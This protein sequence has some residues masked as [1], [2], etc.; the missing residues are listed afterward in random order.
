MG[1]DVSSPVTSVVTKR[2]GTCRIHGGFAEMMGWRPTMEDAHVA[3]VQSDWA[4]L[5]IF[6]GH[7]GGECSTFVSQRL[8]EELKK[9]IPKDDVALS[10]LVM[11]VDAEFL[12]TGQSS[13]STGTF[14]I[15]EYPSEH[16]EKI[17]LRVGNVGDS[18]VLLGRRDGTMVEGCGTDGGL[19]VDHKPDQPLERERIER[20]GGFV[21]SCS[22]V[23]RVNGDLALSRAFGDA[24]FKGVKGLPPECQAVSALPDLATFECD[25]TNIL[26]LV[27]DGISEGNFPNRAAVA[28]AAKLLRSTCPADPANAA[29]AVCREALSNGSRDNLSCMVVVFGDNAVTGEEIRLIPGPLDNLL[30]SAF[31]TSYGDM[32]ARAGLSLAEAVCLRYDAIE[33]ELDA[34]E[35]ETDVD[36]TIKHER[37]LS[38]LNIEYAAFA[39][40][41]PLDFVRGSAERVGWFEAWLKRQSK[42]NSSLDTST[43]LLINAELDALCKVRVASLSDVRAAVD[44]HT[45]L[46]WDD[47]LEETCGREGFLISDDETDAPP[48]EALLG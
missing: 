11:S 37:S 32:A 40:G 19:T 36:D 5:G 20:A 3:Y 27:C 23:A 39:E 8:L 34:A 14:V 43:D 18:R 16:C 48:R 6:D 26:L 28:L 24:R 33:D 47:G 31:V 17:R 41:P 42:M 10:A 38:A 4:F 44:A 45:A 35:F 7:G 2:F 9:G 15:V 1:Q 29:I 22:G 46:E 21:E 30:D 25:E 13:G 12:A